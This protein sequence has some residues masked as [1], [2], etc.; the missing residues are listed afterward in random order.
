MKLDVFSGI[1]LNGTVPIQMNRRLLQLDGIRNT[2]EMR[3][4]GTY[5][6]H[7]FNVRKIENARLELDYY[8]VIVVG[9][10]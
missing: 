8:N 3:R 9:Y 5:D 6:V 10:E 7:K 2:I 4:G 1:L